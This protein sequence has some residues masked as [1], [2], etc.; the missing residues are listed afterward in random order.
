MAPGDY[1]RW[2]LDYAEDLSAFSISDV[3]LACA[4]WRQGEHRRMAS[5]GE[6][7]ATCR[8]M[9]AALPRPHHEPEP[10]PRVPRDPAVYEGFRKLIADLGRGSNRM[11]F[12]R[13]ARRAGETPAQQAERL[14]P[15]HRVDRIHAYR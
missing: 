11:D 8:R 14:W 7:M 6:L 15:S 9:T 12:K 3:R 13:L 1:E 2:L 5:P 4:M 10:E